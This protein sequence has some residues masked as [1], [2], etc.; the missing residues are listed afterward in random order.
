M[1]NIQIVRYQPEYLEPIISLHRSAIIDFTIGMSQYDEEA[2]L[3]D[4]EQV[5]LQNGG[6]FLIGLIDGEVVGMGGFQILSDN[7]AELRRMRVRKDLQDRGYGSRLL[8]ELERLAYQSGIRT[9]SFETAKARYLTLEFYRKHGYKETGQGFYG[10]VE[11]VHFSK[12]LK[13][14]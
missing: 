3:R 11:T 7:S 13:E 2:D 8:R 5:Y 6:E 1:K 10:K 4:I 12:E 9:L 14:H